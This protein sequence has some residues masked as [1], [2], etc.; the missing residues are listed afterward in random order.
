MDFPDKNIARLHNKLGNAKHYISNEN[1]SFNGTDQIL[2]LKYAQQAIKNVADELFILYQ[3]G[4]LNLQE[5]NSLN[6]SVHQL[7]I[8]LNNAVSPE[9]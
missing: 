5:Y 4:V 3:R 7:D 6:D 1:A 8:A 2:S 9:Y